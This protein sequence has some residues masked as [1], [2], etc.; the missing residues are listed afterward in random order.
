MK[1]DETVLKKAI[2]ENGKL[3]RDGKRAP[4]AP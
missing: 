3:K 2:E 1:R 4:S